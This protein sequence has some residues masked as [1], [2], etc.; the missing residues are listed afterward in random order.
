M[1]LE[2]I[3]LTASPEMGRV[4]YYMAFYIRLLRAEKALSARFAIGREGKGRTLSFNVYLQRSKTFFIM[5]S[6]LIDL[7][8][9]LVRNFSMS[10]V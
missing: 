7:H 8:A 5:L 3:M 6:S 9:Q 1:K 2:H 4:L 10:G